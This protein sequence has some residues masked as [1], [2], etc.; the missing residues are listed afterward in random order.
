MHPKLRQL[1]IRPIVH[2]DQPYILLR[3]P[4]QLTDQQILVP[5]PLAAVLA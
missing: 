3:D 1:D 5:Q 2:D 4:Q